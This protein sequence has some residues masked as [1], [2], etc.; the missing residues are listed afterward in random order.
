MG[1]EF[2]YLP[3]KNTE[4][5]ILAAGNGK[6][7]GVGAFI[8]PHGGQV[9]GYFRSNKVAR[10]NILPGPIF[11]E[12]DSNQRENINENIVFVE[13]KVACGKTAG[14]NSLKQKILA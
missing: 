13:L 10:D 8:Y 4:Q 3:Q 9:I 11:I 6:Q 2:L 14:Y 12:S 1:R 7:D 5:C